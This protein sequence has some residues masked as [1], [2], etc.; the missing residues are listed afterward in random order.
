MAHAATVR[1]R[2][3]CHEARGDYRFRV[4]AVPTVMGLSAL[5]RTTDTL[6]PAASVRRQFT[7]FEGVERIDTVGLGPPDC[8]RRT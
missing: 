4:S 7:A 5:A 8:E 2:R 3:A 6:R 1:Q